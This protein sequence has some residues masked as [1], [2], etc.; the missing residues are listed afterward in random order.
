[1]EALRYDALSS[2]LWLA[3]CPNSLRPIFSGYLLA[4]LYLLSPELIT[5]SFVRFRNNKHNEATK[6]GLRNYW[7]VLGSSKIGMCPL[8][9]LAKFSRLSPSSGLG[10]VRSRCLRRMSPLPPADRRG[11]SSEQKGWVLYLAALPGGSLLL[12]HGQPLHHLAV[13]PCW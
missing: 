5:V 3:P 7:G 11:N 8:P 6:S 12:P 1:M 2:R 9:A 13:Q 10:R 4:G